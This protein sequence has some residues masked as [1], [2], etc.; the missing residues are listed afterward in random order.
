M[1]HVSGLKY[2][3]RDVALTE[4]QSAFSKQPRQILLSPGEALLL[5]ALTHV[6]RNNICGLSHIQ[7]WGSRIDR[8]D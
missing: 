8:G 4:T 2:V 5:A 7:L 3:S 1:M 6:N